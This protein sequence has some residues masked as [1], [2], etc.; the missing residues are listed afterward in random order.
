MWTH[1]FVDPWRTWTWTS[2]SSG[3]WACKYLPAG[4]L[5]IR[6]E[7]F[8]SHGD[9]RYPQI[10]H[11]CL[12]FSIIN[13]PFGVSPFMETSKLPPSDRKEIENEIAQD[14]H[15]WVVNSPQQTSTKQ[16][17]TIY[18][19]ATFTRTISF[20]LSPDSAPDQC[21][22]QWWMLTIRLAGCVL[23]WW[24]CWCIRR[25][26]ATGVNSQ[27]GSG[28]TNHITRWSCQVRLPSESSSCNCP[29]LTWEVT[30]VTTQRLNTENG[31]RFVSHGWLLG[32]KPTSRTCIP[33]TVDLGISVKGC[34]YHSGGI[35]AWPGTRTQQVWKSVSTNEA[36]VKVLIFRRPDHS[37]VLRNC[38]QQPNQE[39]KVSPIHLVTSQV[40]YM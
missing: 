27:Q 33:G 23:V 30:T 1:P 8:L 39:V 35:R 25:H 18:S 3:K 14:L 26:Q 31:E 7:G 34:W 40:C 32:S 24:W 2:K 36:C 6:S 22:C 13:Q 15:D 17:R 10:I 28:V 29:C 12:G 21:H 9:T 16:V 5:A 38:H 37:M 20:Q 19:C 4:D 11:F